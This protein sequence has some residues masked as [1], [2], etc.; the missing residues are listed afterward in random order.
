MTIH[1]QVGVNLQITA[2]AWRKKADAAAARL[3]LSEAAGWTLFSLLQTGDGTH[4]AVLADA[5][6]LEGPSVSRQLDNLVAAGLVERRDDPQD[7]RAK[8][9]YLTRAGRDICA[10]MD[11]LLNEVRVYL[12]QGLSREDI[13]T[14]FRVCRHIQDRA[15]HPAALQVLD[16]A[17]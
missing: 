4:L 10:R 14:L 16:D 15:G 6:G 12:L 11:R 9:L 1:K 8:A 5:M 7:R 13:D 2:R 17:T 3:G